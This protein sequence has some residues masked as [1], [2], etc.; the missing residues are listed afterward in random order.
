MYCVNVQGDCS[1]PTEARGTKMVSSYTGNTAVKTRFT[2]FTIRLV[3]LVMH[4]ELCT[5]ALLISMHVMNTLVLD[6]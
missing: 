3:S 2:D 4:M 5:S 6:S 1:T